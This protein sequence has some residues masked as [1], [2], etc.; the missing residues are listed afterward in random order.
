MNWTRHWHRV[1]AE[2][3]PLIGWGLGMRQ[4]F[5]S[6]ALGVALMGALAA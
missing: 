4:I 3:V 1:A 6:P 2:L 5:A